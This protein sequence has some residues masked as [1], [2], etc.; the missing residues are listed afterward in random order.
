MVF[1]SALAIVAKG[2]GFGAPKA[3]AGAFVKALGVW[4]GGTDAEAEGGNARQGAGV[5]DGGV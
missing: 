1:D 3:E 2:V 5:P 4:R